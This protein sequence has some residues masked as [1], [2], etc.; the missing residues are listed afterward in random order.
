MV[1]SK[2]SLESITKIPEAK[3]ETRACGGLTGP[4]IAGAILNGHD[5]LRS[6]SA[7]GYFGGASL[8]A[9]SAFFAAA[10]LITQK[11]LLAKV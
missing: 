9:G 11:K 5:G 1:R 2:S 6:Y 4:P 3:L 8:V 10:R 7:P